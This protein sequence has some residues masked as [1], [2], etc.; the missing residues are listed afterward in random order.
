MRCFRYLFLAILLGLPCLVMAQDGWQDVKNND[1][2]SAREHFRQAL[3]KDSTDRNAIEGIIYLSE[4]EGDDIS[5][6]RSVR[7]LINNHWQEQD[8]FLYETYFVMNDDRDL[9]DRPS[10]SERMKMGVLMDYAF[11]DIQANKKEEGLREYRELTNDLNWSVIGPFKN[12]S[13]SGYEIEYPVEKEKYHPDAVY[14]D[15]SGIDL[16]WVECH[17]RNPDGFIH[18]NNYLA[19]KDEQ[20]YYANT[21]ITLPES[22]LVQ[23]RIFRTE[24]MKLWLD[25]QLIFSSDKTI[26]YDYDNEWV[27][28]QIPAGNHRVLL[29][30][31][32]SANFD[33][34]KNLA[35][36]LSL[37]SLSS[38]LTDN[39]SKSEASAAH[40]SH[41]KQIPLI[42]LTDTAGMLIGNVNSA[43]NAL[44]SPHEYKV[45]VT[46]D[47]LISF[48]KNQITRDPE[49]LYPYYAL[50][51]SYVQYGLSEEGEEYFV[52]AY[53]QHPQSVFFKYLAARMYEENG[54]M[55][56]F[57]EVMNGVDMTKT[58]V[59]SL[60]YGKLALI[61]RQN[62][63]D[64]WLAALKAIYAVSPSNYTLIK[65][66]I[67]YYD[68]KNRKEEKTAFIKDI[69]QKYP[70]Y[71]E[72][73]QRYLD[74]D[75]NDN[76]SSGYSY[77]D[78]DSYSYSS[79]D[80]KLEN[81]KRQGKTRKLVKMYDKLIEKE[82]YDVY[83]LTEKASF[84]KDKKHYDDA[85]NT[86]QMAIALS[87]YDH[88]IYELAG[89]L[90][91]DQ[92]KHDSA[93]Y[94]YRKAEGLARDDASEFSDIQAKIEKM[95]GQ[96]SLKRL[97]N[98]RKFEDLLADTGWVHKYKD[99]ESVVLMYTRDIAMDEYNHVQLFQ[100][101]MVKI[102]T[103]AGVNKWTE[104][105]FDFMGNISSAKVI[106][107]NGA[108]I[109]PDMNGNMVVFKN[110]GAGDILEVEGIYDY[111]PTGELDNDFA[112][113]TVLSFDAPVYYDKLEVAVP[114]G[115]YINHR[116][117]KL[118]D[119]LAKITSDSFDYYKWEYSDVHKSEREEASLDDA[120]MYDG[121][122]IS[123]MP[124]WSKVVS[125]YKHRTYKKLETSYEIRE[126]L[127]SIITPGMTQ[128][129]KV[130]AI[131]NYLTRAI[132]YS[133]V[134][135]LQS[136][137]IPKRCGLTLSSRIGDCKDVATVMV[138]MLRQVDIESY[139]TLVKTNYFDH[140]K[141]LPSTYF[142][143][144]VAGY[145]LD[146]KLHFLDM[147][148]DF[149]PEYTL[150]DADAG[151]YALLIKDGEHELFQLPAD[152]LDPSKNKVEMNIDAT[153]LADKSVRMKV[154]STEPG[155]AGGLMREYFSR[156]SEAGQ[157]NMILEK[158]GRGVFQ[159]MELVDYKFE[160]IQDISHPLQASY[161]LTA[162]GFSDKV[163]N[164]Y[165]FRAPYMT[166]VLSNQALNS[167][168]RYN[169]L[170]LRDICKVTPTEQKV[171]IHFPAGY[172][173]LE[174]PQ[175]I[176]LHSE[177]G[178]YTVTYKAIP[179][180][181]HIEKYQRF[182]QQIIP[183]E[184]FDSF[185]KYYFQILEADGT[186]MAIQRN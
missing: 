43:F 121:I 145:Y 136:G 28:L 118:P 168:M 100:K 34:T 38:I 151:A 176:N 112:M 91:N 52:K 14:S 8:Y 9:L 87:P 7:S 27:Q 105:N 29:K 5:F 59:F 69:Q 50:Y 162:K 155:I 79:D 2:K 120:D 103:E 92:N 49:K 1:N 13:G 19:D 39:D 126:V 172:H 169:R 40:Y 131:Y 47:Q 54:K 116:C 166:A 125:W 147:T 84:L 65:T 148:T 167:K 83:Y 51:R 64:K 109:V 154:A 75:G 88:K 73:M 137:Y 25:D 46:A 67:N 139:Y 173:L 37:A 177:Y 156:T 171:D 18:F 4:L 32:E 184:Q 119:N 76:S 108:E 182:S 63:E 129:Q 158:M 36:T 141:Y 77:A 35:Q 110:L 22:R 140:Q 6:K 70:C 78:D 20:V 142:D 44:Y 66:Y 10:A 102:V 80:Y 11:D 164:L 143:H 163:A 89:D 133:Y 186:K 3:L 42:R 153:L 30:Y 90:Y 72:E 24:P 58:P 95:D 115:K 98:T 185:K 62:D 157:K 33:N 53:R 60:M 16:K 17:K 93:L 152:N 175:N 21:F 106:K 127:D 178:D 55:E 146:G 174:V 12:I 122:M 149:Y 23:I 61:D 144:V 160:N 128:Q 68:D 82:P 179:N 99:N 181:I 81:L 101:M 113:M 134:P 56:K 74:A 48:Y 180:G 96:K 135:F 57:Y 71:K 124:D 97:F 31:A 111:Q 159:N 132:K 104:N 130:E 26:D 15:E 114:H 150:T 41:K 107:P 183:V 94:Y 45:Q 117:Y 123:T 165:I 161:K 86:L 138:A 170:N 85:R